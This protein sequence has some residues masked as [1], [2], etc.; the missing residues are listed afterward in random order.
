ME[1]TK[2][3]VT[4]S[5]GM[6]SA[7]LIAHLQSLGHE[8][9]ALSVDYGQRHRVEL[10]YAARFT[11][12]F[13]VRHEFADLRGITKLLSGSSLTDSSIEVPLGHYGAESMKQTVVPNRNMLLLATATALAVN[14]KASFV[15]YA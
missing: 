4:F 12:H 13:N 6:D 8:V 11:K 2:A 10:E 3:I 15:A 7:T 9:I 1:R 5:G 14:E